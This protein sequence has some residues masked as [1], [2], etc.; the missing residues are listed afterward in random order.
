ML[1][2]PPTRTRPAFTLVE[3]LV[4]IAI[5]G[6]L[7]GLLLSAVQAVRAAAAR[8]ACANNMRQLGLAFHQHHDTRHALPKGVAHPPTVGWMQPL[9]GPDDDPYPLLSWQGR[10]LP[11]L[12]QPALW[13][14]IENA[15]AQDRSFLDNPPH[16]AQ[17]LVLPVFLCP[18]DGRRLPA[19]KAPG[20]HPG[21]SGYAG[22]EGA[23]HYLKDGTLFLD[24]AIRFADVTDGLSHTLLV[25][26]RPPAPRFQYGR[27]YGG[28][29]VWDAFNST[30]GVR[31]TGV[32]P[33][34]PSCHDG[35]HEYGPGR[36]ADVCSSFKF[37]SLH[38]R[39]ANWLFADGSVRFLSYGAKDILPALATRAGGESVEVP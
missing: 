12:D 32:A 25:G 9:Y 11:W 34:E 30:L 31:E 35:P 20:P 15:Y 13:S 17:H 4:V 10:L 36:V 14:Q 38:P 16:A 8:T 28:W 7:T 18:A 29:G 6:V 3:L 39:G 22:V 33:L 2:T 21:P 5:I 26:E 19:T 24:S 37:W 1:D 23:N 27:W